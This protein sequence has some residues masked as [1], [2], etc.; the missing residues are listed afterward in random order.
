M[1]TSFASTIAEIIAQAAFLN[2]CK[3]QNDFATF[4]ST[5][6]TL[7]ITGEIAGTAKAEFYWQRL[8]AQTTSDVTAVTKSS[9][10]ASAMGIELKATDA[11]RGALAYELFRA[12]APELFDVEVRPGMHKGGT[13]G[14]G[15]PQRVKMTDVRTQSPWGRSLYRFFQDEE[16]THFVD[17]RVQRHSGPLQT[18]LG[19]ELGISLGQLL[20]RLKM[21]FPNT[22]MARLLAPIIQRGLQGEEVVLSGAFCPD[23][24]YEETGNP[25]LP[26]RY[27]FDSLGEGIGLV[28]QQFARVIPE[29]SAWLTSYKIKHRIVLGIGDFEADSEETLQAV[30]LTRDEFL[31]RCRK[32]LVAFQERI[33]DNLPLTLEMC[34]IDRGNGRFRTFQCEAQ[35]RLLQEDYGR[36]D[37]IYNAPNEVVRQIATDSSAFY[38][39]WYGNLSE[40]QV[41]EK[42]IAQGGEYAALARMDAEDFGQNV[43]VISGDRPQ[44]HAFD[45]FF[46]NVPVLAVK[47]AY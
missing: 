40:K 10:L 3:S 41:I 47:R 15:E 19:R 4:A 18:A 13:K 46:V 22:V 38:R 34:D 37:Q 16:P 43:I 36:M 24:A 7:G 2:G 9:N 20:F 14:V 39:R 1:S 26:Y 29:L 25:S 42:I 28:A 31:A 12:Y 23:Y 21:N 5:F 6:D 27:T 17:S 11:P 44:M 32:S 33:G 35:Q 30:Q 45:Q 8:P